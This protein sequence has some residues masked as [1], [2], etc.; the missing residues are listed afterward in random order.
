MKAVQSL[1]GGLCAALLAGVVLAQDPSSRLI[2][3]DIEAQSVEGALKTF[4]KQAGVQILFYSRVVE[5]MTAPRLTGSYTPQA[6]LTQLL[7][8]TSLR[9]EFIND[10]T[11]AIRKARQEPAA[12]TFESQSLHL[13]QAAESAD[14][15]NTGASKAGD[16]SAPSA[17]ERAQESPSANRETTLNE[18]VVTATKRQERLMDVPM[19]ITAITADEIERRG[20]VSSEDYLRGIPGVNQVTAGNAQ[21]I[22]IRGIETSTATQNFGSG[23]TIATYFGETPTTNTAGLGGGTNIDLKLVD[24]ERVEV[25]RGPQGTAFGNS[26][27]GGAVRIIPAAPKL[28]RFEGKVGAS[29]SLTSKEG[30]ENDMMQGVVNLPLIERKLAVRATAYRFDDS[31]FYNNR[32]GSDAAFRSAVVSQ[33]GVDA[34]A[35]DQDEV[36]SYNVIGGRIA[37]LFQATDTLR[38]TL[39]YLSQKAELDGT[40]VS[41]SGTYDQTVLL[42]PPEHTLRGQSG[43]ASDTDI[44]IANALMEY[45]LGWGDLMATYSH[46]RSGSVLASTY[47]SIDTDW[48][49]S[50]KADSGHREDVGEIRIATRLDGAWNFLGGL[51]IEDVEDDYL[52]DF[53]WYGSGNFF[54]GG[55]RLLGVYDEGRSLKQKAAFGEAS[56]EFVKGLTLTG[57][58]RAYEYDRRS[59]LDAVGLAFYGVNG[60]HELR[61]TEASGTTFRANLS[62]KPNENALLYAGWSQ[63]FRLGQTQAGVTPGVCDR[64]GDGVVDGTNISV[65]STTRVNSDDVD[66]YEIGGKFALFERRL[67]ISADVFRMEWSGMP[68]RVTAGSLA[69]GCGLGYNANAGEA[70]SEGVELQANFQVSEPFRIDFGASRIRA[71]LAEDV[72]AVTPPAFD[73]DRLPASPEVNANL[74]LQYAFEVGGHQAM[75]RADSIYVGSFYST[76]QQSPTT[77]TDGYVKVDAS[78]RVAI[79]NLSVDLF[80]RNLT[81]EDAY[82]FRGSVIGVGPFYGYRWRPRTIGLQLGY[83]F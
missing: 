13:A 9:Y 50:P 15:A 36:G 53:V 70:L 59:R 80:V 73:G 26:S 77:K 60:R 21:T 20:L 67:T 49:L 41:S 19:S 78:A 83:T 44:D 35:A 25:L 81:N 14:S 68:V 31:G 29:Y 40:P 3:L 55:Q 79:R 28:D 66:S 39:S 63:G 69:T 10:S 58:I 61:D 51:Y 65:E 62:Y 47:T 52:A 48:P 64:N 82:T 75:V 71:R 34:F 38:F 33:Y 4:A 16:S 6:A 12:G 54:S 74:G 27:M 46:T 5:G 2:A 8:G 30:G 24:I 43:E 1:I 18:I 11:V 22:V 23:T 42:V 57:G 72:P 17:Q 32:A 76:L 7:S 37:A 45:D 56:W